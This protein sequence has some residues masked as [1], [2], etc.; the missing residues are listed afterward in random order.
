[1]CL[2]KHNRRKGE[3]KVKR[4]SQEREREKVMKKTRNL[5]MRRKSLE[6]M[7][8]PRHVQTFVPL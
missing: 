2:G 3:R 5:K 8:M 6:M 7:I 1:L 4:K